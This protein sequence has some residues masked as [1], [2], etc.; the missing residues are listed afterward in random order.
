MAYVPEGPRRVPNLSVRENLLMAARAG[1]DAAAATGPSACCAP[2]PVWPSGST[3]GAQ[4]SGGEQQMLSIGRALMTQPRAD[5]LD[6][7]TEGW[8]R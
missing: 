4:L 1:V 3:H 5:H 7:A 6:E 8:R 2:F